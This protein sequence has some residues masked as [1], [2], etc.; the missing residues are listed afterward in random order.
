MGFGAE[1]YRT[2]TYNIQLSPLGCFSLAKDLT[3]SL[4]SELV[5]GAALL[6]K[7]HGLGNGVSR[8][9]QKH[10]QQ[11]TCGVCFIVLPFAYGQGKRLAATSGWGN[12]ENRKGQKNKDVVG[13]EMFILS[14]S[15]GFYKQWSILKKLS[16]QST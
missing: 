2:L 13:K 7:S 9:I 11:A 14:F 15:E 3:L 5:T 10:C 4:H 16:D 1:R 8:N 6:Q 12:L